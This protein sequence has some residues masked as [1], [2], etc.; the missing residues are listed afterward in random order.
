MTVLHV[1][2]NRG[3]VIAHAVRSIF[4]GAVC[5]PRSQNVMVISDSQY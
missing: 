2:E 4:V 1:R 3:A 5:K